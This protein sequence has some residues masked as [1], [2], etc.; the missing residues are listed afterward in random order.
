MKGYIQVYIIGKV[1]ENFA[2]A[3]NYR[4]SEMFNIEN[5]CKI[6]KQF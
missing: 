2:R 6:I 1:D 3:Q 4:N 5:S